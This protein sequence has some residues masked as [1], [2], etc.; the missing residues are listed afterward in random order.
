MDRPLLVTI[1]SS[2]SLSSISS[3]ELVGIIIPPSEEE[4]EGVLSV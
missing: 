4:E 1:I 3:S 2:C